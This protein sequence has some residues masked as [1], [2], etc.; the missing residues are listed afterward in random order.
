MVGA[1]LTLA[2]SDPPPDISSRRVPSPLSNSS[3]GY[4]DDLFRTPDA[5][6]EPTAASFLFSHDYLSTPPI[7]NFSEASTHPVRITSEISPT[8]SFNF[9]A[10][11]TTDTKVRW[12]GV[13]HENEPRVC[14]HPRPSQLDHHFNLPPLSLEGPPHTSKE[15]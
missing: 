5:T 13:I 9:S 4:L 11:S 12:S 1:P 6:T 8:N 2:P 3:S 14:H 15:T 7:F 10:S